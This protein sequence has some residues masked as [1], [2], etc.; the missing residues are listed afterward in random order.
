MKNR[1]F[2]GKKYNLCFLMDEKKLIFCFLFLH[3]TKK[4]IFCRFFFVFVIFFIRR[5]FNHETK[6]QKMNE[7]TFDDNSRVTI[8]A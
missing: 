1:F 2:K 4:K 7:Y 6:K 3:E 5:L 8:I